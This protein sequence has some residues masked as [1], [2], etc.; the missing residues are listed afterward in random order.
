MW[1]G[2]VASAL[3]GKR[4]QAFLREMRTALDE[5]SEPRLIA[6][7]MVAT[8]GIDWEAGVCSL[9][10]VGIRR[11]MDRIE[12][13]ALDN[14]EREEIGLAFGIAGAMAAEIQWINDEASFRV[15]GRHGRSRWETPE[16]RFT[17]V[18]AWIDSRLPAEMM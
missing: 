2:A 8:E 1:R 17:R 5:L 4:G 11:K 9:G 13:D 7:I 14:A 12:L 15:I 16:Q 6:G 18:R 3:R 10:A